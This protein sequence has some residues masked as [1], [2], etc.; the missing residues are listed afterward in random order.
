VVAETLAGGGLAA[1]EAL[2]VRPGHPVRVTLAQRLAEADDI[3]ARPGGECA[4]EYRYDGVRVQV[5]RTAD[6]DIELFT[7]GLERINNQFPELVEA[8][9]P[10]LGPRAGIPESEAVAYDP[11]AGRP[12]VAWSGRPR[13]V[14]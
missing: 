11:R 4:V 2:Q 5:H 14:V 6:G 13:M 3:L 12:E 10:A 1:V 9:D 7:R 8:L